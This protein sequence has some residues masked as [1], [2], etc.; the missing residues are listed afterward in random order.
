[1]RLQ[2]H[3]KCDYAQS[4]IPADPECYCPGP[5]EQRLPCGHIPEEEH[6]Y[7]CGEYENE[8]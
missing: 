2:H 7:E 8:D 4:P 3:W 6:L 5:G 1:M